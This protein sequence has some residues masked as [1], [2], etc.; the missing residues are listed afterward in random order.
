MFALTSLKIL[1]DIIMKYPGQVVP[2]PPTKYTFFAD[3]HELEQVKK[4]VK[5]TIICPDTSSLVLDFTLFF[6]LRP[7]PT[8]F[9][10][11]SCSKGP[12]LE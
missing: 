6:Q 3:L 11:L 8:H 1:D 9:L 10:Y 4:R 7:F 12:K 5:I 2:P